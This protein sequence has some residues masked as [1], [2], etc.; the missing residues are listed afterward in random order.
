M[1]RASHVARTQQLR[2]TR[3]LTAVDTFLAES[4]PNWLFLAVPDDKV[5]R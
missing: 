4:R 3:A 1:T 2:S 5:T